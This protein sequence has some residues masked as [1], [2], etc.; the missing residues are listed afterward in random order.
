MGSDQLKFSEA[1]FKRHHFP[2]IKGWP[3][4]RGLFEYKFKVVRIGRFSRFQRFWTRKICG[5]SWVINKKFRNEKK[6]V[7]WLK[8]QHGCET[9]F[10]K[11]SKM[12]EISE[13]DW[14]QHIKMDYAQNLRKNL[15]KS[16]KCNQI[17]WNAIKW[18]EMNSWNMYTILWKCMTRF[19]LLYY[20]SYVF[21][22]RMRWNRQNRPI[23]A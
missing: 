11:I 19:L 22:F 21:R 2:L 16:K 14:A 6:S 12:S 5:I 8:N 4:N 7:S 23:L 3:Q 15:I 10:S 17:K 18:N 1:Y 13:M 20:V 9:F